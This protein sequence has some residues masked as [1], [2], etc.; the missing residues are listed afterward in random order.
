MALLF[1]VALLFGELF[2]GLPV[3]LSDDAAVAGAVVELLWDTVG[4]LC[5]V[6]QLP[7]QRV[8]G[9]S[10]ALATATCCWDSHLRPAQGEA[11][12]HINQSSIIKLLQEQSRQAKFCCIMPKR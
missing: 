8:R 12:Q 9:D 6:E 1:G 5:W 10:W 7:L 11:H 2:V 3:L 4:L